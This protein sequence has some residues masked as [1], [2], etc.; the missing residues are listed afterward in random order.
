[1]QPLPNRGLQDDGVHLTFAINQFGD[2]LVM[3]NAWPVGNL[4][5]LQVL[6]AFWKAVSENVQ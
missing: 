6:D 2:P 3:R 5:A 1:V 4:T